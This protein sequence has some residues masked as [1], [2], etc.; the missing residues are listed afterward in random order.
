MIGVTFDDA[1]TDLANEMIKDA[2]A[3]VN[4]YLSR[5]YDLASNSFQTT[6][7]IPP[8][9]RAMTTRLAEGYM[10]KAMSRGSK[11]S[12]ARGDSLIKDVIENLKVIAS[13][14]GELLDTAGSVVVDK[15][16]TAYKVLCNTSNYSNTINEDSELKWRIDSDKLDDIAS[17]R[18]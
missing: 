11:E 17:E 18:D 13:Y 1:T 6:T 8:L 14:T 16:N 4:K 9:V 10:W 5:R 7:S 3:E 2:D 15:E 12:I